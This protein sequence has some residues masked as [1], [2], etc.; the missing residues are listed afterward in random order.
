MIKFQRKAVLVLTAAAALAASGCEAT[1]AF[2][3]D[4]DEFDRKSSTFN[5]EVTDR[6]ALSICYNGLVTTDKRIEE[7][8]A[9][10]CQ[11]FGKIA[12]TTGETFRDCP[13]LAPVEARFICIPR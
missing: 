3:Y 2:I 9:A 8:A 12:V 11:K 13:L 7:M 5:K 4:K 1:Q 6:E 10:E